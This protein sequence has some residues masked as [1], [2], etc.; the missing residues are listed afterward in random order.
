M[1]HDRACHSPINRSLSHALPRPQRSRR[2]PTVRPLRVHK[3]SKSLRAY[4]LALF[5]EIDQREYL[6]GRNAYTALLD[7][8][9]DD[10]KDGSN[11]E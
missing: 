11:A 7:Q 4:N 5:Y 6:S 9:D 2:P 1:G 8:A 3:G 10:R